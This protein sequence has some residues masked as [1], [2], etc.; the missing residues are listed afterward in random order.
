MLD[1]LK[2]VRIVDDV[3]LNK[4]VLLQVAGA[5]LLTGATYLLLRN[6]LKAIP[7]WGRVLGSILAAYTFFMIVEV[8]RQAYAREVIKDE[9]KA[10]ANELV[11]ALTDNSANQ[12]VYA[13]GRKA[14]VDLEAARAGSAT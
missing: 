11:G 5:T 2:N 9:A 1:E 12:Q 13:S 14:G 3:L 6:R 10:V 4:R 8:I 7:V